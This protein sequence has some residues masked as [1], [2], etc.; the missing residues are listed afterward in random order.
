MQETTTRVAVMG[1]D[2]D[3]FSRSTR[4]DEVPALLG[5][6]V[7]HAPAEDGASGNFATERRQ[8]I[9]QMPAS[10]RVAA[11]E[12][13]ILGFMADALGVAAASLNPGQDA[14]GSGL[15]S[16]MLLELRHRVE[17]ELGLLIPVTALMDELSASRIAKTLSE[18]L[19]M[20]HEPSD[21]S[22]D[23]FVEGEI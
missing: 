7:E 1:I 17:V 4:S 6:M 12:G 18:S 10:D 16:L 8:A 5:D 22:P 23:T 20:G 21:G 3:R 2:W 11:L 15:D 9:R 19:D 13:I 14:R